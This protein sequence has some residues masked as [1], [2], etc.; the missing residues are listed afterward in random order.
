MEY[1]FS[2]V[3]IGVLVLKHQAISVHS[4]AYMIIVLVQFNTKIS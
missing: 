4:A 2:T 1:A 3:V